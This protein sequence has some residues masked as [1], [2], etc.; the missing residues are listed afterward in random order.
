MRTP[1]R[2]QKPPL[3]FRI[4][5]RVLLLNILVV[6]L[7]IVV[8]LMLDTY[9]IQLLD[10]LE[11]SLVQQ[12]R[13]L[14]AALEGGQLDSTRAQEMLSALRGAH[15]A[16]LRVIDSHG[17]LLADTSTIATAGDTVA[18]GEL[19]T[20]LDA[21]TDADPR[22]S[23][24]YRIASAPVRLLRQIG[25]D[26]A[27]QY[28]SADFYTNNE[29]RDGPEV[30]T[31]L[32]GRYGA[33]T[34]VSSGGQISVTLYS[35]LPIRA[36]GSVGGVVLVSQSTYRILQNLYLLRVDVFAVF[37]ISAAVAAVISLFLGLTIARPISILQRQAAS[38]VDSHGRITGPLVPDQRRDE[39][40]RL[41]KALADLTKQIDAHTRHLEAFAADTSHELKNPLASIQ[42]S[43]E[44][45]IESPDEATKNRFLLRIGEDVRRAE[46]II[47]GVR[48][49]SLIDTGEEPGGVADVLEVV[50][51]AVS[52]RIQ[53]GAGLSITPPSGANGQ[54]PVAL[55]VHRLRQVVDNLLDNAMSFSPGAVTLSVQT[56]D[57]EI[58]LVVEDSGPGLPPGEEE[59]VFSR[60][61]TARDERADHL[62]LGLSIVRAIV[63]RARGRVTAENG[64]DGGAR[65]VVT[66]PKTVT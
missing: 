35:A 8:I 17:T 1:A 60:F 57:D 42:A 30:K 12:G 7:P 56:R 55:P 44:V 46:A 48:E 50:Q 36:E 5:T 21:V 64:P 22:E 10:M 28:G 49:L 32:S 24:I 20:E 23:L 27:D 47:A 52:W 53:Q 54:M 51:D 6:F 38:L 31:A 40:G 43:C 3:V 13:I 9:E 37:V 41:A 58:S 65:F 66:L 11:R 33:A 2:K 45:A 15:E 61:Y 59:R 14:A 19:P 63:E 18:D 29:Y 34:R 25:G 39:V 4:G 26:P 16:R 62:G